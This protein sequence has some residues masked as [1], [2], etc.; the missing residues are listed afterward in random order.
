MFHSKASMFPA[1]RH[2]IVT[3]FQTPPACALI[4]RLYYSNLIESHHSLTGSIYVEGVSESGDDSILASC[5][6]NREKIN[7]LSLVLSNFIESL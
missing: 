7:K 1:R 5:T 2:R 6:A 4:R 3:A